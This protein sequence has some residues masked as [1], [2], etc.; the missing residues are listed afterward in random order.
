MTQKLA[1]SMPLQEKTTKTKHTHTHTSKKQNKIKIQKWIENI[2][3]LN[4]S[5]KLK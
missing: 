4:L 5:L 2:I 1:L 3:F